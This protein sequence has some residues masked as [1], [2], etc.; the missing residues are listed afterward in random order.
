MSTHDLIEERVK[1]MPNLTMRQSLRRV[2]TNL[3]KHKQDGNWAHY[4]LEDK[5]GFC[6]DYTEHDDNYPNDITN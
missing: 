2:L 5:Y 6:G 1:E 3:F 4:E